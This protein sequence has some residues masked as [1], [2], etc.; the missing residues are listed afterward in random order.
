[1][2]GVSLPHKCFTPFGEVLAEARGHFRLWEVVS[3]LEHD[4][5]LVAG[6]MASAGIAFQ[7]HAPFSDVNPA[8]LNP[9]VRGMAV[10]G[11]S[12]TI[13][14]SADAGAKVVTVH[15]GIISP[16]GSYARDK[17]IATSKESLR[18]LGRVAD[19]CGVALAVENMPTGP[20]A[21]LTTAEEA[22]AFSD[23]TGLRLCFDIGHAHIAGTEADFFE[24]VHL[25]ANVHVHDNNRVRDEHITVGAGGADFAG[26]RKALSGYNGN[27]VIEAR[28]MASAIE[29]RNR[30]EELGFG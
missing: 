13:R 10:E 1:M 19:E 3:E 25:F 23:E 12:E 28:S 16:M 15:P 22:R 18:A 30:L 21:F 20:W 8:S 4:V 2:I 27:V 29:S 17:V 6:D 7:V 14:S 26:L 9:R 24:L 5:R 11:L